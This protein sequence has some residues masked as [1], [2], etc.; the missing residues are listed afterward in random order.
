MNTTVLQYIPTTDR[1][2]G[3]SPLDLSSCRLILN[4]FHVV[5][6][7]RSVTF[8]LGYRTF[9]VLVKFLCN[10][11]ERFMSLLSDIFKRYLLD[12]KWIILWTI[13]NWVDSFERKKF[14]FLEKKSLLCLINH[15]NGFEIITFFRKFIGNSRERKKSIK[16]K[17]NCVTHL[18]WRT[19]R[20][21]KRKKIKISAKEHQFVAK[22]TWVVLQTHLNQKVSDLD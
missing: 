19:K 15:W 22:R 12:F 18:N 10:A 2:Y 1:T 16:T 5:Y 11:I 20:W 7:T 3:C 21:F 8:Q 6:H 13:D 17:S 9:L 14:G 4:F